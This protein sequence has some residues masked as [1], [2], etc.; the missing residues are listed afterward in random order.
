MPPEGA[1]RVGVRQ[2]STAMADDPGE[3]LLISL[4]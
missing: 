4:N 1:G 2:Q 3:V